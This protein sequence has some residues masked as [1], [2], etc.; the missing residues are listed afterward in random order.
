[1]TPTVV[2]GT[3]THLP[4]QTEGSGP[5]DPGK[6]RWRLAFRTLWQIDQDRRRRPLAGDRQRRRRQG[7]A[8]MSPTGQRKVFVIGFPVRD[9]FGV[10]T[11]GLPAVH[12]P[13]LGDPANCPSTAIPLMADSPVSGFGHNWLNDRDGRKADLDGIGPHDRV[14]AWRGRGTFAAAAGTVSH[15]ARGA[16]AEGDR[17]DPGSSRLGAPAP[18]GTRPDP[19]AP[20][21]REG[22]PGGQGAPGRAAAP[23][24]LSAA[25]APAP[26][27]R[28]PPARPAPARGRPGPRR[29][30]APPSRPAPAAAASASGEPLDAA[31]GRVEA[32]MAA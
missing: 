12:G 15:P 1:M 19:R 27:H 21:R 8:P 31:D 17:A 30:A 28:P 14:P 23:A 5:P 20:R 2:A 32:S 25:A 3:A 13:Q 22:W 18:S 9:W 26:R 29:R 16:R 11:G 24:G 10:R 4:V 6:P 7:G